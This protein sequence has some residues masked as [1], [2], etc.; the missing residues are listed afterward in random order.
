MQRRG[1]PKA[2]KSGFFGATIAYLGYGIG[3]RRLKIES[4]RTEAIKGL[5][6]SRNVTDSKSF[7]GLCNVIRQFVPNFAKIALP[8][9]D[10]LLKDQPFIFEL[11]K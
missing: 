10:K 6:V 4:R 8:P 3:A 5:E 2:E 11:N 7:I 1:Y 9:D